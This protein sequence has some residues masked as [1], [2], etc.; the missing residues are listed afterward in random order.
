MA[1]L[2]VL[3]AFLPYTAC[4]WAATQSLS[5]PVRG[6][7]LGPAG[8]HSVRH[9]SATPVPLHLSHYTPHYPQRHIVTTYLLLHHEARLSPLSPSPIGPSCSWLP[10]TP[11]LT[12]HPSSSG[13]ETA[14]SI[15]LPSHSTS[16]TH[17]SQ[18]IASATTFTCSLI[19]HSSASPAVVV[20]MSSTDHLRSPR[21]F[22]LT[23]S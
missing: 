15:A 4:R 20:R 12:Q 1:M 9:L 14:P 2:S 6:S 7:P 16:L 22:S 18:R 8:S 10:L 13:H 17:P 11:W 5:P 3:T 23:T 21:H 19:L